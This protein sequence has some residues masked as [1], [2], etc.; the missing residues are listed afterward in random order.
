M[1]SIDRDLAGRDAQGMPNLV[2]AGPFLF[3]R[4][5]DGVSGNISEQCER[6]YGAL[7][8]IFAAAGAGLE[9]VVRLDHF[10]ESQAWLSERQK[11]RARFFGR[12]AQLAST[13]VASRL[14]PPNSLRVAAIGLAS[15]GQKR[16]LVDGASFGMAAIS[17]V[18]SAGNYLFLSGILND[19][20]WPTP[21]QPNQSEFMRQAAG[22]FATID[23]LLHR[24]GHRRPHLVRQDVYISEGVLAC[25]AASILEA[26]RRETANAVHGVFLPFGGGDR[27]EV[28]SI[29]CGYPPK[30][31]PLAFFTAAGATP[32]DL[33]DNLK[34][35][36]ARSGIPND[37]L[38]RLDVC[39]PRQD[40]EQH[41]LQVISNA[42]GG[43]GPVVVPYV[44]ASM[45]DV[46][47]SATAIASVA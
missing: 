46:P 31:Q 24:A 30:G 47:Y 32:R 38:V 9:Q 7:Q 19:G 41:L 43:Q 17:S 39:V 29:A 27:L 44:G 15:G 40:Q 10:T 11:V 5:C 16:V 14:Q 33:I 3:S 21:A 34:K 1:T 13:G 35:S 36:A 23:E 18:V 12:P 28:T 6:A 22:C 8:E 45:A 42:L 2:Q 37:R 25:E 20:G 26:A 4:A